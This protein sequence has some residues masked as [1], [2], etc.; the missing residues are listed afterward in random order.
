MRVLVDGAAV[1]ERE[2][3]CAHYSPR[4]GGVCVCPPPAAF[5]EFMSN[6]PDGASFIIFVLL[7]SRTDQRPSS[8]PKG[9]ICKRSSQLRELRGVK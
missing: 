6:A 9:S 2:R 4:H 3:A 1:R 7:R 5:E 8:L